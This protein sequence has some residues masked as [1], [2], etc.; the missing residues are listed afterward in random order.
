MSTTNLKSHLLSEIDRLT[1][2]QQ[3]H[4]LK[5]ARGMSHGEGTP[6][7]RLLRFA[8]S[9]PREDLQEIAAAIEE[10]C[11]RVDPDAW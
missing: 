3:Q 6:V 9:I 10:G 2:P 11:E 1:L 7:S 4:L 5:I 8:G